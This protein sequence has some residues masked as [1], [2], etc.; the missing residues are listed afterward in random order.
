MLKNIICDDLEF[1]DYIIY[2]QKIIVFVGYSEVNRGCLQLERLQVQGFRGLRRL[3]L[4]LKELRFCYLKSKK[5]FN[6]F[7]SY[8]SSFVYCLMEIY[9]ELYI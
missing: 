1:N 3:F 7:S 2:I 8:K 4:K 5:V 9:F 6:L